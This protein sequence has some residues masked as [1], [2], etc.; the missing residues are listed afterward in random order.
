VAGF[1]NLDY[2][3]AQIA[4]AAFAVSGQRCTSIS[5]V[6]ILR[7]EAE[8]CI[9][10]IADRMKSYVLGNGMDPKVTMGPVISDMAGESIMGHIDG[11]KAEGA[12]I[13]V[14][15]HKLS[16]DIYDKGFYIE[17]TLITDVRPDMKAAQEEIF[18]P[19]LVVIEV[20]SFEEAIQVANSGEYGL[21]A[22]LFSDNLER[23]YRF[24]NEMES[25][26]THVNHGTVTDSCMPFGGV[27]NS[28][29]GAFS[30]GATNKDFF[31][32]WKVNYT[33]FA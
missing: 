31:T 22:A 16:G 9:S 20:D 8:T 25:G 29:L 11:A 13:R 26:M 19:V 17:P 12:T 30:K 3:S 27:K 6:I 28:G 5:R 18:G 33:K 10:K 4:Q 1:G 7:D 14:G 21:A 32:T 24:Q 23:I 15:G 2:A